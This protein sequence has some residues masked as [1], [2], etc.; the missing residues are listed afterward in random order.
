MIFPVLKHLNHRHDD[1]ILVKMTIQTFR[2]IIVKI[3]DRPKIELKNE[4]GI[5]NYKIDSLTKGP[6]RLTGLVSL[7]RTHF[8]ARKSSNYNLL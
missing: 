4:S 8:D 6:N 3:R 7:N 5:E 1:K 2:H